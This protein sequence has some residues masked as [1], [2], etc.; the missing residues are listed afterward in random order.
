MVRNVSK[1]KDAVSLYGAEHFSAR[2]KKLTQASAS[3]SS[4]LPCGNGVVELEFAGGLFVGVV[5]CARLAFEGGAVSDRVLALPWGLLPYGLLPYGLAP[6]VF[7]VFCRGVTT[8][9]PSVAEG[10]SSLSPDRLPA[11]GGGCVAA[12][13]M[14]AAVVQ[15]GA[16]FTP[17]GC[18]ADPGGLFGGPGC[19]FKG[20]GSNE[21]H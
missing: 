20:C 14:H 5:P 21:E 4:P 19:C 1:S 16:A 8:L 7:A 13:G 6:V 18:F 17:V 10:I 2:A 12:F 9:L 11:K 15:A 3:I